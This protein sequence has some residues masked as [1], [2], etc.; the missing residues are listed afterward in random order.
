V[1]GLVDDVL[2]DLVGDGDGVIGPAQVGDGLEL[3]PVEDPA[4][5]VLRRVQHNGF[6]LVREGRFQLVGVEPEV[7][8]AERHETRHSA[9]ERDPDGVAVVVGLDEDHLIVGID[10]TEEGGGQGLGTARSDR[11]LC[12]RVEGSAEFGPVSEGYCLS[13]VGYAVARRI[14][15]VAARHRAGRGFFYEVGPVPIGE[16][17][18]EIDRPMLVGQPG[19]FGEDAGTKRLET[20]R[21]GHRREVISGRT[22]GC[23][24]PAVGCRLSASGCQLPASVPTTDY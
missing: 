17:L 8:G 16:T 23:R 1:V 6:C 2:V 9:G 13:Q 12:L 22:V 15:V 18:P 4:R 5:R 19:H 14:L 11:D 7:W 21:R 3:A 20:F 10:Q 24:L